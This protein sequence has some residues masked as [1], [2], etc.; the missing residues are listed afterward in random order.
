M[1]KSALPLLFFLF[2][3]FLLYGCGETHKQGGGGTAS[4]STSVSNVFDVT[5]AKAIVAASSTT[6][7]SLLAKGVRVKDASVTDLLKLTA[8]G[9][10]A[11][12]LNL[13]EGSRPPISVIEK[14]PDGCL[15]VG[16]QWGFWVQDTGTSDARGTSVCFV[17][18]YR[19]GTVESVDNSLHG[20]GTWYGDSNN[21]DLPVKQVQFD[22]DGNL[23]YLG[24]S[25]TTTVLKKKT[26]AGVISQIGNNQMSVRDFYVCPNGLVL[27][28][29]SNAGSWSTEWLR[30]ITAANSV[31]NIFYNSGSDGWLRAY[32]YVPNNNS[33]I[34]VGSNLQIKDQLGV[35][36][37]YSGITQVILNA[38][39]TTKAVNLL[40]DDNNMYDDS[41][42]LANQI[43]Y[44]YWDGI[45]QKTFFTPDSWG[46]TALPLALTSGTSEDAIRSFIREKY[47]SITTDTLGSLTFEAMDFT[48]TQET[49][50][51][52]SC[53]NIADKISAEVSA[54]ITGVTW[55]QWKDANGLKNVSFGWAKQ[56]VLADNGCLYA[57]MKLDSW[58]GSTF[59]G[60]RIYQIIDANGNA[61]IEA[62]SRHATYRS[63]SKTRCYGNYLLCIA[64]S[65]GESKILRY[66]LTSPA[67]DPADMT[68]ARS[69]ILIYSFNYNPTNTTL[70]YDVYN[71]DNN[72]SALV[73]QLITEAA[74]STTRTATGRVITDVVP[75]ESTQ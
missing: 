30:V 63:I 48:G 2:F 61:S 13:P 9:E 36:K 55:K 6:A 62:F 28:H 51:G 14:G 53:S 68:S 5:G 37:R 70:Y 56:L 52:I 35:S 1:K 3:S 72:T 45:E 66:T 74:T 50:H 69:N 12:I 29:G 58:S 24:T 17:K 40:Y 7:S 43:M 65:G 75:F 54:H 73:E 8:T 32:Y 44:G 39:A 49:V 21:G 4:V 57:V 23:Y 26:P 22:S 42:S 20:V 11:S 10:F 31:K 33:I 41:R 16:F 59:N 64:N 38:D 27:F 19:E 15:Y 47:Y 34:L 25:G 18:I 71:Y 67:A 46:G 60:D